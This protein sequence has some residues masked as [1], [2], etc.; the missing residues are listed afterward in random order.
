VQ[1]HEVHKKEIYLLLLTI[2]NP[3]HLPVGSGLLKIDFISLN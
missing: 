3:D 2:H 1:K